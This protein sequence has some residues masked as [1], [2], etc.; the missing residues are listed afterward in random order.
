MIYK[1]IVDYFTDQLN[2]YTY[3]KEKELTLYRQFDDE[4]E[5]KEDYWSDDYHYDIEKFGS[6][7]V[8][9]TITEKR[10]D[11]VNEE[12]IVQ[13]GYTNLEIDEDGNVDVDRKS[14][15]LNSSHVAISYAVFCLK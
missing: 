6:I 2:I 13:Y 11:E 7:V 8:L 1:R 14:T 9:Y 15:R 12:F 3:D 5:P 4:V 10:N